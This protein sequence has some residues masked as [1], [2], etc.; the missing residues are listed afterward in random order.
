MNTISIILQVVTLLVLGIGVGV[1]I[2]LYSK[3]LQASKT[4]NDIF[5]MS[6]LTAYVELIEK[7]Q[8]LETDALKKQY[9]EQV[10]KSIKTIL[11]H[12]E[13]LQNDYTSLLI[14]TTGYL[15]SLDIEDKAGYIKK[16]FPLNYDFFKVTVLDME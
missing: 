10:L 11:H 14:E 15:R 2:P 3:A 8:L 9:G 13:K 1:I 6:K 7:K 16:H 12:K 4:Y 5:D